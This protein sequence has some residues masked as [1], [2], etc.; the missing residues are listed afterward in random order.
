VVF[1]L[2]Q[3][4]QQ[5]SGAISPDGSSATIGTDTGS[6][7]FVDTRT[8]AVRQGIGGHSNAVTTVVYSPDG[9]RVVTTGDDDQV[10]VWNPGSAL[11]LEAL[12]GH[13]GDVHGAAFS[14]D[15][16]TLFTSSLDG[17]IFEWD[18]GGTRG[19]GRPFSVGPP[20]PCC[21]PDTP[22]TPPL[23]V[24]PSGSV[25]ATRIGGST[26]GLFS[27]RTLQKE[28]QVSIGK[29]AG[30]PTA[31]AWSSAGSQLAIAAH[32]G[33]LELWQVS[34]TPRL[35]RTFV[36]L[37]SLNGLPEALQAV[38]F[39][40][41]GALIAAA[42]INHT[43]GS[44]PPDGHVAIWRTA[45]GRL[46]G[47]PRDL[48]LPGDSVAFSPS[49]LLTVGLDD[50]RVVILGS[51]GKHVERTLL[52]VGGANF[53]GVNALA[54]AAN[55]TLATGNAAG[56]VQ[57]WDPDSSGALG[58]PVLVAAAPVASIAFDR[59]GAR[60][61]TAGGA[62]GTIKLWSTATLQQVGTSLSS[63][64]GSWGNAAFT[65][66][67]RTLIAVFDNGQ[68]VEWPATLAAWERHAC[69]VAGRNLTREEWSRFVTGYAYTRVCP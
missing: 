56:L 27:T 41:D 19:F 65:P 35:V 32:N 60:F 63:V 59:A 55:G 8:G 52:P 26:I 53:A 14:S 18:L 13:A 45:T 24:S 33:V 2:P 17:T 47:Q 3:S 34:G 57:L 16:R 64:T 49:G 12:S 22:G 68:G 61:V 36:G 20:L 10:R 51:D 30:M 28:G 7:Y 44:T 21:A 5:W 31:V 48:H 38:S 25:F 4:I 29:R 15:G 39:S 66:D 43:P 69:A 9:R 54:F 62:D 23:A 1:H 67:D 42:D 46:V 50:G 11:A 6:V 58:H 40:H 37:R